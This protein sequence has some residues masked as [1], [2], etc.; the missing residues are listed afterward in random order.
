MSGLADLEWLSR[1]VLLRRR[2]LAFPGGILAGKI[3]REDRME[4]STVDVTGLTV[5]MICFRMDVEQG[6]G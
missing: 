4:E 3:G 1:I 6:N 2:S 5:V